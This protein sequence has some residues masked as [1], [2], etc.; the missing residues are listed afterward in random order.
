VQL[1][2]TGWL[3]EKLNFDTK[4]P[5]DVNDVH[6]E[7][8]RQFIRSS[9]G[10]YHLYDEDLYISA[11]SADF[12]MWE[13]SDSFWMSMHM[14]GATGYVV[15]ITTAILL[16]DLNEHPVA[17]ITGACFCLFSTLGYFTGH[18]APVLKFFRCYILLWNPF[19]KEPYFMLRLKQVER[20]ASVIDCMDPVL[21]F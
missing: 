18:Y 11:R 19:M 12:K 5:F 16:N 8:F 10:I 13:K 9:K 1:M 21:H 4:L 2:V 15:L 6:S 3:L 14:V 17:W 7:D 20:F